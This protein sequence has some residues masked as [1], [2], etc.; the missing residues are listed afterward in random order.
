MIKPVKAAA[1]RFRS[2]RGQLFRTTLANFVTNILVGLSALFDFRVKISIRGGTAM[3]RRAVGHFRG[4]AH[5]TQG[6]NGGH[7]DEAVESS[8]RV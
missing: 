5:C 2:E 8:R 1:C 6:F 3:K 4:V 7:G